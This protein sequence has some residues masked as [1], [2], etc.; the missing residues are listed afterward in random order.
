M[1]F[2]SRNII[3]ISIVFIFLFTISLG[4]YAGG[5]DKKEGEKFNPGDLIMH[6][7]KDSHEWHL[8]SIGE[9]HVSIPLPIILY[10]NNGID[11]FFSHDLFSAKKGEHKESEHKEHKDGEHKDGEAKKDAHH[12]FQVLERGKNVYHFSHD[13][14][15]M[16]DGTP[17][18][19]F[20]ITKNVASLLISTLLLIFVFTSIAKSYKKNA[21][22]APKGLQSFFEPLIVFVRDEIAH[23]NIAHNADKYVPYLLTVFFFIWFNNMLGLIPGGANA[24]G[25]IAVTLVLALF[26]F[27][28]TTFSAKS[29][30]WKHIFAP[31]VPFL[32]KFILIPIEFIGIFTKPF[33][34]MVRLF[35]NIMA[36][37]VIILSLISLIFIFG[38]MLPLAG[39]GVVA[40][41]SIAFSTA[42]MGLEM[43]VAILQAYVF[44]ML[45][46]MYIGQ[47]VEEP[48]HE[49]GAA[50]H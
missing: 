46:S 33:S 44:T 3:K 15:T 4:A 12:S 32:L 10:T 24:T 5:G 21:G 39:T 26:T 43:F 14:I 19:D 7:I 17:V 2:F 34:L 22:K 11:V 31:N 42:M 13:K 25:N 20:S 9:T 8:I 27:I 36:G 41:A 40:V 18:W 1:Q 49:E 45:T 37:H 35:A 6:H 16:A 28:I 47:A 48:H 23:K 38:A 30:Y 50:H 29:T